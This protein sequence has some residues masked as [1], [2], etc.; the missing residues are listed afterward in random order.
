[1]SLNVI[2]EALHVVCICLLFPFQIFIRKIK[3]DKDEIG[4]KD[5]KQQQWITYYLTSFMQAQDRESVRY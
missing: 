1:M 3:M 2:P 5:G 4:V